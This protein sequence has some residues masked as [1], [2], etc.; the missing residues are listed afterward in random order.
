[1]KGVVPGHGR[2]EIDVNFTPETKTTAFAEVELK[3]SQFGFKP[4]ITK[5][6]GG[7][8]TQEGRFSES[9]RPYSRGSKLDPLN[10]SRIK[11]IQTLEEEELMDN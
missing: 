9:K 1:M 7:A 2:T 10:D 4:I 11:F 6:M 8:K 5:I 3:I